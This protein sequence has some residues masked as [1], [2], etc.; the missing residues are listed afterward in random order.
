MEEWRRKRIE[1]VYARW[2]KR[3]RGGPTVNNRCLLYMQC[4]LAEYLCDNISGVQLGGVV[5]D[6]Q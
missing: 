1:E 5:F 4:Q 3:G 2:E 6:L